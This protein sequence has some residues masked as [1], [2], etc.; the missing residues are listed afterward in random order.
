MSK[1]FFFAVKTYINGLV[2]SIIS[3]IFSIKRNIDLAT[4][5]RFYSYRI[6]HA[7][8]Q[9]LST[10]LLLVLFC[11]VMMVSAAFAGT[12]HSYNRSTESQRLIDALWQN[13]SHDLSVTMFYQQ[14]FGDDLTI[15][16]ATFL[17]YYETGRLYGA[18]AGIGFVLAGPLFT[19]QN[20]THEVYQDAKQIFL[21]DSAYL[22]YVNTR[23]GIHA[24]AGRYKS[25]E[26]WNTFNS[27]GFAITYEGIKYTSFHLTA[28]YGSALVLNEYVTP[29][30]TDLSNFGT[31][32]IRAKFRL[33][34]HIDL[35]PYA[36]ITGF[37]T[38]FGVKG[39]IGYRITRD[40]EMETKLH[41]AAYNKYYKAPNTYTIGTTA[42]SHKFQSAVDTSF[43]AGT[44]KDLSAIA[45][46]EQEMIWRKFLELKLGLIGVTTSGAELIDYY[47]HKAP[48]E[49]NV[50]MFWGG[51]VTPYAALGM[52]MYH[53]FELEAGIR[54]TFSQ[55]GNIFSFEVKGEY[56]FS[57]WKNYIRGKIGLSVIGVYNKTSYSSPTVANPLNTIPAVNFY[58]GNNYT[59][60][61]GFIRVSI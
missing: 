32:L 6:P 30:R 3:K 23:Y 41:I 55:A 34:F 27:Q 20:G 43:N 39:Q 44:G 56:D 11:Y 9:I 15:L 14:A 37:F 25:N 51:A 45:W 18:K 21:L 42:H 48:F 57:I 36:Y 47:G 1:K 5:S 61:R 60:I 49:Y 22:D 35:E 8:M 53:L 28:S 46:I 26:E 16:D 2:V 13:G 7:S 52:N 58:G 29:F 17:G 59:L 24:I 31:Y 4:E 10:R 40:I 19:L 54:G 50:G 33:P 38:A 12:P